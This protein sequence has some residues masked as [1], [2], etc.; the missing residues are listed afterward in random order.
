M[1]ELVSFPSSLLA[2]LLCLAGVAISHPD[3]DFRRRA[4]RILL[5]IFQR[6]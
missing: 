3:E 6:R 1:N 2:F 4:E 5:A